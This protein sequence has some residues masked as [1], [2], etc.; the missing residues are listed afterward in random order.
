MLPREEP[1][2]SPSAA[3]RTARDYELEWLLCLASVFQAQL[4]RNYAASETPQ[5]PLQLEA[6]ASMVAPNLNAWELAVRKIQSWR[7]AGSNRRD[8]A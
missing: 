1:S 3:N 6:P 2:P 4:R 8:A 5:E 7:R